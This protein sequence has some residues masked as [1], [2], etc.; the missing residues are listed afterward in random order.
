LSVGGDSFG[1]TGTGGVVDRESGRES[2]AAPHLAG[3][4]PESFAVDCPKPLKM[5][6]CRHRLAATVDDLVARVGALEQ[7]VAALEAGRPPIIA[8]RA[9]RAI[10]VTCPSPPLRPTVGPPG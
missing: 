10:S 5:R 8:Y 9:E 2:V 4:E 3:A 7:R 1:G 6:R